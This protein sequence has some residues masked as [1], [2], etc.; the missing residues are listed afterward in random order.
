MFA[1]DL[2]N[3]P[4]DRVIVIWDDLLGVRPKA[5]A[6]ISA[7]D[8]SDVPAFELLRKALIKLRSINASHARWRINPLA[9]AACNHLNWAADV[10]VEIVTFDTEGQDEIERLLADSQVPYQDFY[11]TTSEDLARNTAWRID[12]QRIYTP[13]PE[14][15]FRYGA[16]TRV[17]SADACEIDSLLR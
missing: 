4:V 6:E 11:A 8:P 7:P 3:T 13:N 14:H 2:D 12:V 16:R 15:R 5:E 9:E 17:V 1:N 10:G